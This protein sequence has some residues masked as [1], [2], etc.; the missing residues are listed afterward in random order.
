MLS[1]VPSLARSIFYAVR[2]NQKVKLLKIFDFIKTDHQ[3]F[4]NLRQNYF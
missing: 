3:G 4:S 2:T 1:G